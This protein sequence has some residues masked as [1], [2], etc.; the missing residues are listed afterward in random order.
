MLGR[1]IH[2]GQADTIAACRIRSRTFPLLRTALGILICATESYPQES[3]PTHMISDEAVRPYVAR[4]NSND[5]EQVVNHVPNAAAYDWMR[6]NIPRFECPDKS[7][8]EIYYFRWWSYRKHIKHTFDGFV[9]TEYVTREDYFEAIETYARSHHVG[10]RPYVGEYLD[11]V[12]GDWIK[13][14]SARSRYYN[15]STFTDLVISGLVGL[16]PRSDGVIEVDT[17]IPVGKW[18]W[19][20]L[21][22]V[23]YHGR[24]VTIIWDKTGERYGQGKGLRVLADGHE[25]AYAPQL[26]RL[27][28]KLP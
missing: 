26:E 2:Q 11:E 28:G 20:C 21:D 24:E 14:V 13:G 23:S 9:I 16:K 1:A 5:D 8:E 15:H 19:F 4:F 7:I 25:I 18:D 10:D 17:L 27:T 12:T 6:L 3:L 22:H